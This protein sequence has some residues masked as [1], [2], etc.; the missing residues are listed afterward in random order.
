MPIAVV[1]WPTGQPV[2]RTGRPVCRLVGCK[3]SRPA[4]PVAGWL[5]AR[6]ARYPASW[7]DYRLGLPTSELAS[8]LAGWLAGQLAG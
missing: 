4:G 5:V 2:A 8:W 7:L 6:P 3:P 1:D